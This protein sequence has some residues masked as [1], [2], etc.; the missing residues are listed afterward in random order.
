MITKEVMYSMRTDE[1][2][3]EFMRESAKKTP[4]KLSQFVQMA[5]KAGA[6]EIIKKHGEE[7]PE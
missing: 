6:N 1:E 7:D 4:F 2:W 5:A 3:L